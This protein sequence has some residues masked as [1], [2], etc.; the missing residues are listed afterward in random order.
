MS[1]SLNDSIGSLDDRRASFEEW[2]RT[3]REPAARAS[4]GRRTL[5]ATNGGAYGEYEIAPLPDGRFA[6]RFILQYDSGNMATHACPW[7]AYASRD[8]CLTIFTEAAHRH[9][10]AELVEMTC[11]ARQRM[12]RTQ[13]LDVLSGGLFGF[14]EP[15]PES[16]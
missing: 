10:T 5:V 8:D 1:S 14:V 15:N 7:T 4:E 6:I 9:F 3:V 2:V 12:A 13:T 16:K 11:S